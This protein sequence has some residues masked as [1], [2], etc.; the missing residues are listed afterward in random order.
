[1][2]LEARPGT[3]AKGLV[4]LGDL[5][6]AGMPSSR[7]LYAITFGRST[8]EDEQISRS[9]RVPI[10]AANVSVQREERFHSGEEFRVACM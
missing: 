10:V 6:P 3:S 1:M 8:S 9:Q 5:F 2:P 4:G 7:L